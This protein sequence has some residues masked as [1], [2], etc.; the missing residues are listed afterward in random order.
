MPGSERNSDALRELGRMAAERREEA[1]MTLDDIYDRTR[2][3]MEYLRG[4][5]AGDYANFP[6][7]VYTRGFVRTYLKLIGAED[8]QEDFLAQL[9]RLQPRQESNANILGNGSTVPKGFKPASHLWLFLVLLAALA[10]TGGYVWYAWA[11]GNFTLENWRW[12]NFGQS[13]GTA[14]VEP[15]TSLIDEEALEAVISEDAAPEPPAPPTP[16]PKPSIAFRARGDVWMSVSIGGNSVFSRTL[17]AGSTV[18]WDL[19]AQA[20]VRFGRPNAV[21]VILNGKELGVPNPKGSKN[22]ETYLYQPDGTYRRAPAS[23]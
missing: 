4:I 21:D 17:K 13:G 15:Q 16:A 7:V 14:Q 9:N 22:A 6:E 12:P 5:E 8:L 1:N 2:I 19:P 20:R 3:R 11:N 10:G 23:K 18:S